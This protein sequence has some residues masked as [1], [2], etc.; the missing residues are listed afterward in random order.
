MCML[1]DQYEKQ[2]LVVGIMV[3]ESN[4]PSWAASGISG[5]MYGHYICVTNQRLYGDQLF[6]LR[7]ICLSAF[8]G[9]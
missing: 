5:S 4:T 9:V 8:Y 2:V 7:I 3:V 1:M 6:A